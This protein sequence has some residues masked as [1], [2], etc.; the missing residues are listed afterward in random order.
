[1]SP[2]NNA[3]RNYNAKF[4]T[5]KPMNMAKENMQLILGAKLLTYLV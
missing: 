4:K 2:V 5:N 3:N 1:M